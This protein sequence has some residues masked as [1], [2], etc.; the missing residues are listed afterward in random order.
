M[1]A[2]LSSLP[3]PKEEERAV[4][5]A[6]LVDNRTI[7][8][9][10]EWLEPK[11]FHLKD[12]EIVYGAMVTLFRSSTPIDLLTLSGLLTDQGNLDR[13]G[14]KVFLISIT[15]GVPRSSNIRHYAERVRDAAGARVLIRSCHKLSE[16]LRH[17]PQAIWDGRT[18]EHLEVI[19]RVT[20]AVQ[21]EALSD[22]TPPWPLP[23]GSAAFV[24][25]AGEFVEAIAPYTEADPA[26]LLLNFLV[27]AG[28]AFGPRPHYL[29]QAER[30]GLNLYLCVVGKSSKARKGHSLAPITHLFHR[31]DPEW[32]AECLCGGLSTGEGLIAEVRDPEGAEGQSGYTPGTVDK[33]RLFVE[34]EFSRILKND[35][36]QGNIL[37]ELIRQAWDSGTLRSRTKNNPLRAT[38]AHISLIGHIT[39]EELRRELTSTATANGF[40]NRHLW[41]AA[42]RS[43]VIAHPRRF[44][45]EWIGPFAEAL[46]DRLVAGRRVERIEMSLDASALWDQGGLYE[47]LSSEGDYEGI[48][49]ALSGRAEAH[50]IRLAAIYALLDDAPVIQ[51]AHLR[52][53]DALWQYCARS[54]RFIFGTMTGDQLA[55]RI[56]AGVRRSSTQGLTRTEISAMFGKNVSAGRLEA[57]LGMLDRLGLAHGTEVASGGRPVERW[58]CGAARREHPAA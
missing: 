33:R 25:L 14:G 54:I 43:G 8:E 23:P 40:G 47:K 16:I 3:Y 36:R 4:L 34:P 37:S 38:G 45:D 49:A 41:A 50:V 26:I 53:A 52:A 6:I 22:P 11:H 10:V 51:V 12:H 1:S 28:N 35:E 19:G 21:R 56:L 9:V 13:V 15:D 42:Q 58:F 48:V 31:A 46:R 55:D 57:A 2:G 44:T 17:D 29:V 20:R 24:G 18:S 39:L 30:H 7:S 27:F 5:G 32:A